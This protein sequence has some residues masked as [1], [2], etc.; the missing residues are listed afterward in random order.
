MSFDTISTTSNDHNLSRLPSHQSENRDGFFQSYS[1]PPKTHAIQKPSPSQSN[2]N[3][4]NPFEKISTSVQSPPP[5]PYRSM[6]VPGVFPLKRR[7]SSASPLSKISYSEITKDEPSIIKSQTDGSSHLRRASVGGHP[8]HQI[9]ITYHRRLSNPGSFS[10]KHDRQPSPLG[11]RGSI[12]NRSHSNSVSSASS[13]YFSDMSDL[14]TQSSIHE[15]DSTNPDVCH[16]NQFRNMASKSKPSPLGSRRP[17]SISNSLLSTI[18][19]E[20]T[21]TP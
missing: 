3:Q 5:K 15:S 21:I 18:D 2:L 12:T 14:T 19:D 8:N 16:P 7:Q 20:L 10:L 6:S 4:T 9:S 13:G 17:L 1:F 11:T